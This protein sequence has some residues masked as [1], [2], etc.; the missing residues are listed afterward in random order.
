MN[1]VHLPTLLT[2]A[3]DPSLDQY[4][5]SAEAHCRIHSCTQS[6]EHYPGRSKTRPRQPNNMEYSI[7]SPHGVT[8]N[9]RTL[10]HKQNRP[11]PNGRRTDTPQSTY[12]CWEKSTARL[13]H[14]RCISYG[15]CLQRVRLTEALP[16]WEVDATRVY[17]ILLWPKKESTSTGHGRYDGIIRTEYRCRKSRPVNKETATGIT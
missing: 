6:K 3:N 4:T 17:K 16:I 5:H 2:H 10:A 15:G 1:R 14:I 9:W 13:A 12:Y 11:C 8:P 7:F